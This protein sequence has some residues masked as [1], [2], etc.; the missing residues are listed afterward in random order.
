VTLTDGEKTWQT[1]SVW[2]VAQRVEWNESVDTM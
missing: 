2:S 1:R